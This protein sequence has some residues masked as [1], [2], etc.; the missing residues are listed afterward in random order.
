MD[1]EESRGDS[2][3][4]G[5]PHDASKYYDISMIDEAVRQSMTDSPG[6]A[7]P[8]NPNVACREKTGIEALQ[9]MIASLRRRADQLERLIGALPPEMNHHASAALRGLVHKSMQYDV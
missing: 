7:M 5:L 2:R 9:E 1:R 6:Y 4:Y 8:S 3:S